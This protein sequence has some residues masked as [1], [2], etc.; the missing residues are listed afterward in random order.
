MSVIRK[1]V[2]IAVVLIVSAGALFAGGD[3]EAGSSAP[4]VFNETGY[5]IVDEMQTYRIVAGQRAEITQDYDESP[6]FAEVEETTNVRIEWDTYSSGL[7]ERRNLIFAFGDLPDAFLHFLGNNDPYIYGDQ[8]F[9]LP[10]QGLIEDYMPNFAAFMEM[11]PN[12]AA[13]MVQPDG[14]IYTFPTGI[15]KGFTSTAAMFINQTWLDA[16]GLEKPT[17]TE[18]FYDVLTAFKEQ[19]PNGNGVADETPYI[20]IED[21]NKSYHGLFDI[22]AAFGHPDTANHILFGDEDVM[23]TANTEDY[24][25]GIQY[26]HRLASEGL[27]DNEGFTY[28]LRVY[29]AKINEGNVGVFIDWRLQNMG[30]S[31][32]EDDAEQLLPLVGPDGD[33]GWSR[34]VVGFNANSGSQI[35][36]AARDPEVMARW[37]DYY[38]DEVNSIRMR[39]GRNIELNPDGETFTRVDRPAEISKGEW[40]WAP[41]VWIPHFVTVESFDRRVGFQGFDLEKQAITNALEPYL[42]E[43]PI[44]VPISFTVEEIDR[45]NRL[46]TE[47]ITYVDEMKAR[48]VVNGGIEDDWDTYL[49]QLDRLGLQEYIDIYNAAYQRFLDS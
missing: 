27:L 38:Y 19:D 49:Q 44:N 3:Q 40:E 42:T 39:M 22:F 14:N 10:V 15:E 9:L 47:L 48:W 36:T 37:F 26:L 2:A 34:S 25:E 29:R 1:S 30:I 17:T 8:G 46:D 16:L 7:D 23:F 18:E 32:V 6:L 31:G 35:T 13:A 41:G 28:D 21:A 33:Q 24:K 20:F 5:P 45:L 43:H 4:A 12:Y 11:R